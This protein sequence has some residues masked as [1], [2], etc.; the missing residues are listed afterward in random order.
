[1]IG[2]IGAFL[3]LFGILMD[4]VTSWILFGKGMSIMETNPIFVHWGFWVY[5]FMHLIF[6]TFIII[7]WFWMLK[8]YKKMYNM[9][10]IGYK[11]A[12]VGIF[13]FCIFIVFMAGLKTELGINNFKMIVQ[14]FDEVELE[15]TK[16]V[17][18]EMEEYRATEPEKFK[19]QAVQSYK[20]DIIVQG[21][22][23]TQFWITMILGYLLFRVGHKVCPYEC[24]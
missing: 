2:A 10:G 23:Y 12:D 8:L 9:H 17:V 5:L 11:L 14:N 22:S 24:G 16:E 21:L 3:I 19:Q 1:M 7:T 6:Y 18:K 4:D 15:Q 13:M 20:E